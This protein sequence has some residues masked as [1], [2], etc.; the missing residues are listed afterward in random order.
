[1]ALNCCRGSNFLFSQTRSVL[2]PQSP[3]RVR[4]NSIWEFSPGGVE[5]EPEPYAKES[6]A[7]ESGTDTPQIAES[8]HRH[9]ILPNLFLNVCS[10]SGEMH[11]RVQSKHERRPREKPKNSRTTPASQSQSV[12]WG[13][14]DF[15]SGLLTIFSSRTSTRVDSVSIFP[16][17]LPR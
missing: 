17:F 5:P 12:F 14:S 8:H 10:Q 9:S 7:T 3:P 15:S 4:V 1:M 13:S 6:R 11:D 16:S 2:T